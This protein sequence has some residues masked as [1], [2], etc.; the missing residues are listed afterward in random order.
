M[1]QRVS[2]A[3]L[4]QLGASPAGAWQ[5]SAKTVDMV[6]KGAEPRPVSVTDNQREIRFDLTRTALLVIDMQNDF[7][8]PEG[9]LSSIGVDISPA[10][11]PIQPLQA[12]LPVLRAH[13]VPV[14]WVNWGNR[15]D[16]LNLPPAVLHV[17][18]PD[19]RGVGLGDPLPGNGAAVLQA[20][21]WSAQVVDELTVEA[22]DVQ[23]NK[24]RMSGFKDTDLDSILRNLQVNTLLFAGVNADQ[25]VLYTLQDANSA[26]YDCI[27]LEDCCATT[28]PAYCMAAAVYNTRQCFGF[29]AQS[30]ELIKGLSDTRCE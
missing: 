5:V 4:V 16:R 2:A 26:G 28:S 6:R 19:G 10:R 14:V 1:T 20:G 27:L 12:L 30:T 11:R 21:S 18:N 22:G 9:W 7:C 17:Y 29:V 24:F 8:H 23:V 13:Q 3:T 25:C 15:P